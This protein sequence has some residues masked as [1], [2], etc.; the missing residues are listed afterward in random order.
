MRLVDNSEATYTADDDGERHG[1]YRRW[2]GD[3]TKTDTILWVHAYFEH[4]HPIGEYKSWREDGSLQSHRYFDHNGR[5]IR[6]LLGQS[7]S[8]ED[9]FELQLTHGGQWL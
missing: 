1:E 9:R 5:M 4:G 3:K 2:H 6:D 8:D 7:L